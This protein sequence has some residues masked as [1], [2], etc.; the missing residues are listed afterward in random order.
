MVLKMLYRLMLAAALTFALQAQDKLVLPEAPGRDTTQRLCGNTCHGV[1]TWINKR[2]SREGWDAVIEDMIRRGAR[3]EDNDW[4][5]VSDYLA[6]AFNKSVPIRININLLPFK[7]LAQSLGIPEDMAK[8]IVK[9]RNANGKF[10]SFED[11][12]K[13]PGVDAKLLEAKKSKMEF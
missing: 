1:A 11:L 10:A 13:V 12:L 9:Y 5:D 4:A 6:K 7:P 8:E 2:E 3:A